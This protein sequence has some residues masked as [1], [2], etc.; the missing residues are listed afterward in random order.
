MNYRL[1]TLVLFFL[2]PLS[3]LLAQESYIQ[4]KS[5]PGVSV[6]LDG[7]F[8][9]VTN[10][11][12]DGIIIKSVQPGNYTLKFVREGYQPISEAVTVRP[13]EV[14]IHQVK[15]LVPEIK[16][17]Q[18][19]NTVAPQVREG[20]NT[21]E[22]RTGSLKIQSLPI[23]ITIGIPDLGID[24]PKTQDEWIAED[25]PVGTYQVYFKWKGKSM[26]D[27]ITVNSQQTSAYLVD[28]I[29]MKI[30]RPGAGGEETVT[31]PV[32]ESVQQS[33]PQ[34]TAEAA[35]TELPTPRKNDLMRM[36][37]LGSVK[38]IDRRLYYFN[39]RNTRR[40]KALDEIL[41]SEDLSSSRYLEKEQQLVQHFLPSGN[42]VRDTAVE[43]DA[44][45]QLIV[46]YD[47]EDQL[48]SSFFWQYT[49]D[50]LGNRRSWKYFEVVPGGA[51]KLIEEVTQ[52][53]DGTVLL[54]RI[55]QQER[56]QIREYFQYNDKG[57]T[58][59]LSR[60]AERGYPRKSE[61]EFRPIA[62]DAQGNWIERHVFLDGE[63]S[64]IEKRTIEYYGE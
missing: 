37:L 42:L 50:D 8:K 27:Q 12:L 1:K 23:G 6:F 22:L 40:A 63:L 11:E 29:D 17:V 34:S 54:R 26:T 33:S 5:Q 19:G 51:P 52:E 32:Q 45:G 24:S 60:E 14:Y 3:A 43:Y 20:Q 38:T 30:S 62:R 49:Y 57:E 41:D 35:E 46:R 16:I 7:A 61:L 64:L 13:G 25:I 59:R 39:P 21:M 44:E 18:K 9:G 47:H 2:L 4:I 31:P 55:T 28:F 36:N 10:A 48:R 15:T 56:D 53:F 58:I